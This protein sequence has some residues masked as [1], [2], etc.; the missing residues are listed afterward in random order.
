MI[1]MGRVLTGR[2]PEDPAEEDFKCFTCSFS[3]YVRRQEPAKIELNST[4]DAAV[5]ENVPDVGW[6][7][8]AGVSGG[9]DCEVNGDCSFLQGGEE[10]GWRFSGDEGFLADPNAFNDKANAGKDSS[11]AQK[12]QGEALS[13]KTEAD[14]SHKL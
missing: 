1:A 9:W 6:R 14:S 5:A 12:S 7:G 4:W 3:K 10:R 2:M 13:G 11:S 8:G